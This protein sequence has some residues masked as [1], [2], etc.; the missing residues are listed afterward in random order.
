MYSLAYR[1]EDGQIEVLFRAWPRHL[2]LLQSV[3]T[4]FGAHTV[5]YPNG[6][7]G[8]LKGAKATRAEIDHSPP[9]NI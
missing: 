3:Q 4:G 9:S 7:G 8:S 5:S 1:M 6:P 2:S